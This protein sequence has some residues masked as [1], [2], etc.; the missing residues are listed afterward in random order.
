MTAHVLFEHRP[1]TQ[2]SG[3]LYQNKARE[4]PNLCMAVALEHLDMRPAPPS[5]RQVLQR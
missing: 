2:K 1:S 3:R 4:A 5:G